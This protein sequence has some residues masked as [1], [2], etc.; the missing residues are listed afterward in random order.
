MSSLGAA[1]QAELAGLR[2][3]ETGVGLEAVFGPAGACFAPAARDCGSQ[4]ASAVLGWRAG[5]RQPS[6]RAQEAQSLCPLRQ[7][8][9]ERHFLAALQ[10]KASYKLSE[11]FKKG[12]A[13]PKRAPKAK[14]RLHSSSELG[15]KSWPWR[16][17]S[18]TEGH[19][20]APPEPQ[21]V[22]GRR[23][24]PGLAVQRLFLLSCCGDVEGSDLSPQAH[25][26][27]GLCALQE[28]TEKKKTTTPKVPIPPML[29]CMPH[30]HP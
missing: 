16:S 26:C 14:V 25:C 1:F 21:C 11:D 4:R 24:G 27:S 18:G 5:A 17:R 10:V 19:T 12:P 7:L 23:F 3:R 20:S 8:A 15:F 9:P 6:G 28:P 30:T 22:V 29:P 2:S 13:K